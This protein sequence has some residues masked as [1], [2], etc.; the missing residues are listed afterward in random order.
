MIID[1]TPIEKYTLGKNRE[2][3]V[4]REDLCVNS[5][6]PAL[7]KLRGVNKRLIL[8]KKKGINLVGVLDT[9]IS[10]QRGGLLIFQKKSELK[11]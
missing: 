8:L 10:N 4:K 11:S 3:F 2:V 7:A 1:N 5:P 9:Q 6:A